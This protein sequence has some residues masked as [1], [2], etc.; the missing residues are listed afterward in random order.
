MKSWMIAVCLVV[1]GHVSAM[2][3]FPTLNHLRPSS[4]I[5][6]QSLAAQQLIGRVLGVDLASHFNVTVTG[7]KVLDS[8]N[9]ISD[10]NTVSITA[11]TGVAAAMGFYYYL[12]VHC[13]CQFTWA[14]QQLNIPSPLPAIAQ[15]GITIMAN[16]RF[17][18]YQNVCTVSYSMAW[19]DWSQWEQH[20]DWMAMNG[21]NLPLA[22][23]GQEAVFQK[24]YMKLG[25]TADDLKMHWGGP[26]FL[27]WSRMGNMHGWG[28]PLPQSWIDNQLALQH[29]I[30]ARMRDLG[31]IPVLPGFSG[32][33]PENFTRL[34]P[35]ASV[36]R[37]S[38]WGGFNSSYCCTYLLDFEDPMFNKIGSTFIQ[39][40]QDEF[41]TDHIY[42]A[43]S[44]N[45]MDPKS[46]SPS[47]LKTA[48]SAVY[49]A[50][51]TADPQAIWLMQ[52]WLFQSP[53][54]TPE[55]TKAYLTSVPIGKMIVLDL[56]AEGSPIYVR[57]Q[58][59]YGQP[60]IWCMLHNFGGTMELFGNIDAIN[61]G[62]FKG[63]QF[64]GST[65]VGIGLTP[66]GIF[67]N[68]AIYEF[69]NENAYA[70]SPRN[71]TEWFTNYTVQRYGSYHSDAD[72]AWQLLRQTVYRG[73]VRS[74][75]GLAQL[76]GSATSVPTLRPQLPARYPPVWYDTKLLYMAWKHML[77][78]APKFSNNSLF[79]YD[80]VDIGRNSLQMLSIQYYTAILAAYQNQSIDALDKAGGAM[81][82]ILS[83]LELLLGSDPHF[84]L[85]P[86]IRD[87]RSWGVTASEADL[88]EY[89][90]RNQVTL[91]GPTG[92]IRDY[93][94]KQWAGL[95]SGYYAPR[96]GKFIGM[97]ALCVSQGTQFSQTEYNE[98]VLETIEEPFC[99]DTTQVPVNPT[100]D[101]VEISAALYQKYLPDMK[102][103]FHSKL[104]VWATQGESGL[105]QAISW[106][107]NN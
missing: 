38:D 50:M 78:A 7:A 88:M 31:M 13:G 65:M 79:R 32:L 95:I 73:S 64:T 6:D 56:I 59:F 77:N 106:M 98:V 87:A 18:Y 92:E 41:G 23:T 8:F 99:A 97:L 26:A 49:N 66:E 86:W 46:S 103:D 89:N 1:V 34:Y 44:F 27:A 85:G 45:E 29:Q 93:A 28:G 53:F 47:Y 80:L 35:N 37:L 84:L 100:G 71:L 11:T 39:T 22:F 82:N 4:S 75:M 62:P 21:I 54:W 42:N 74:T 17:R 57:T 33:V 14:G 83:D 40:M 94:A 16:D 9:I 96:W 68:E 24:T 12:K 102:S 3:D 90:A 20:I 60:F 101:S 25:F 105:K 10:G 43:D 72:Q 2:K 19:W 30:L 81:M 104:P 91:W 51:A 55:P 70:K 63:R 107:Y 69:M 48:G 76:R 52:G 58:S 67:Q 15:P 36:S 5:A 61:N